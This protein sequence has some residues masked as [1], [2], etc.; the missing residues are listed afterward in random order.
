M[1]YT[2]RQ[3]KKLHHNY[4]FFLMFVVLFKKY[5]ISFKQATQ[6]VIQNKMRTTMGINNDR[7]FCAIAGALQKLLLPINKV[8]QI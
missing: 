3:T 7:N 5:C 8:S 2:R 6:L 1:I 4:L